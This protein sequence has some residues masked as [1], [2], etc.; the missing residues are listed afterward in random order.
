MMPPEHYLAGDWGTSHLRL[1]LCEFDPTRSCTKI[2]A[3]KTGLGVASLAQQQATFESTFFALADEWLATYVI[4]EIILAGMVGANIGWY[5]AEYS[6]CPASALSLGQATVKFTARGRTVHI[7]SGVSCT[8]PLGQFDVMRG[9]E[10]QLLG[11]LSQQPND[12]KLRLFALPGTHNKWALVK[13]AQILT[14]ATAFTG[15][16]YSLL[17]Q[18]SILVTR[19]AAIDHHEDRAYDQGVALSF[20][21]DQLDLVHTLFSTRARQISG[22][23]SVDNARAYLSG[24]IIGADVRG[25]LSRFADVAADLGEAITAI[26]L[27]G[28]KHLCER[29]ARVI[30]QRSNIPSQYTVAQQIAANGFQTIYQQLRP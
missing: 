21:S 24:L 6:A 8:N 19:N 4:K 7:V 13:G 10:L 3:K 20:A 12:Q 5:P 28:E 27:I 17:T 9:E 11:W 23:L 15:E 25:A 30:A 26:V 14:F 1:Y 18:H 2:L 16:L 22:E 29:Y